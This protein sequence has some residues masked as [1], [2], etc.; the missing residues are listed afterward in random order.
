MKVLDSFKGMVNNVFHI[1]IYIFFQKQQKLISSEEQ[2]QALENIYYLHACSFVVSNKRVL[3][4]Y[5]GRLLGT[6]NK[7]GC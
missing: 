1:Y 2:L 4:I 5:G 6:F 7:I 3:Y